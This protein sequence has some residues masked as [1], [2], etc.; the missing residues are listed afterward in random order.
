MNDCVSLWIQ[1]TPFSLD[2][3]SPAMLTRARALAAARPGGCVLGRVPASR[4]PRVVLLPLVP[5]DIVVEPCAGLASVSRAS[6]R[7]L[8]AVAQVEPCVAWG[9]AG[10]VL[11]G[12]R[13]SRG[14]PS[15]HGPEPGG[16]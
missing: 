16:G 5:T 13:A 4:A 1:L 3:A 7:Q 12:T 9:R 2:R 11:V 6:C 10:R 14:T 15:W 8:R